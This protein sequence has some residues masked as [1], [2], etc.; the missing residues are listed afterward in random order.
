MFRRFFSVTKNKM[1]TKS[2]SSFDSCLAAGS[3]D[4]LERR[5]LIWI[6][7]FGHV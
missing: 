6:V 4:D 2:K 1:R 5:K 7:S 3:S